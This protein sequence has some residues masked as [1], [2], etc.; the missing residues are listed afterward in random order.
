MIEEFTSRIKSNQ[1]INRHD[2]VLIAVS[3]GLDSMVLADIL[4]RM[5]YDCGIAHCNFGLRGEESDEDENFVR[6]WSS[7]KKI[8]FFYSKFKTAEYSKEKG[9]SIQMAARDLRYEWFESIRKKEDYNLIALAHH[10]DDVVE[11]FHLNLSRG[12]GIKGLTGIAAKTTSIV[13]PLL[14]ASRKQIHVYAKENGISY[15]EDSSNK[16]TDYS[17]NRI[18]LNIIPEF[19][20]INP[21][22]S[23]TLLSDIQH[24]RQAN[25]ILEDQFT[26]WEKDVVDDSNEDIRLSIEAIGRYIEPSWFLFRFL[27]PFGFNSKQVKSILVSLQSPSGRKFHSPTH[28]LIKDR[29]N[30]FLIR[31]NTD[32]GTGFYYI[33][34]N[35]N[36][37]EEPL[38]IHLKHFSASDYKIPVS[39]DIASLDSEKLQYPLFLRRWRPGDFFFPFGMDNVK[40]LSDYFIDEKIPIHLKNKIWLLC[41]GEDIIW[42][43]GQ[44]IDNRYSLNARTKTI[45]QLEVWL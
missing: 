4:I 16:K 13:R 24:I 37:L 9:I 20:K 27:H 19:H 21:S 35:Q 8:D 31:I 15:R 40:K 43:I 34:K 22:Y 25:N 5:G 17:R 33:E 38:L 1:L 29:E 26:K 30:L 44:R 2:K 32:E 41:S 14:W 3:G 18:R 23:A 45:L 28:S 36:R 11:T 10:A 6:K 12:T 39:P 42:I 7:G